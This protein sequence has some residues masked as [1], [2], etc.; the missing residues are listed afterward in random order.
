M[1]EPEDGE[2]EKIMRVLLGS[3]IKTKGTYTTNH[4]K[5]LKHELKTQFSDYINLDLKTTS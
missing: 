3:M 5:S 1:V 4:M 2:Q